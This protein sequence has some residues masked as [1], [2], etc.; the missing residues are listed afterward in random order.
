[1]HW[2]NNPKSLP[3]DVPCDLPWARAKIEIQYVTDAS[4]TV[5]RIDR[6]TKLSFNEAFFCVPSDM[7]RHHPLRT[8]PVSWSNNLFFERREEPAQYLPGLASH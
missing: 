1:M 7:F 3:L 4:A 2:S 5:S 6:V 8:D